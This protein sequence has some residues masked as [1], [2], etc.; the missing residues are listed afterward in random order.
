M[1][2]QH[3]SYLVGFS[4]RLGPAIGYMWNGRWCLRSRPAHVHNPRSAAQV[5]HRT[6]FKAE[7]QLAARLRW[8]LTTTLTAQ[9][10]AAGMTAFNLFV[11][12]NQPCFALAD[13]EFCVDWEHLQ[14]SLG[15]VAPVA[16]TAAARTADNRLSVSFERNPLGVAC[17]SHDLVYLYVYCPEADEGCLAAPVY[18]RAQRVEVLLPDAMQGREVVLYAMVQDEA[19]RWSPTAWGGALA[20]EGTLAA[21]LADEDA[22]LASLSIARETPAQGDATANNTQST[23][24]HNSLSLPGVGPGMGGPG[25]G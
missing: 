16:L 21:A 8:A 11:S 17:R 10:R 12:M 14:L 24:Y 2:K 6:L 9:A 23:P 22:P 4:G 25:R 5:A 7:V 18:R 1:A 13:S 20:A 15:P 19:G 3:G